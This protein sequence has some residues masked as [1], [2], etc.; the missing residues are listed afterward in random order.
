[1]AYH[2]KEL[3]WSRELEG[4]GWCAENQGVDVP[5]ERAGWAVKGLGVGVAF[6]HGFT[7][8]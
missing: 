8:R 3:A 7:F 2:A 5:S 1:M 6:D 4:R